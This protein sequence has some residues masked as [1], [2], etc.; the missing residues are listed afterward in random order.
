LWIIRSDFARKRMAA[1][2]FLA[3]LIH[4]RILV[5]MTE[6]EALNK[7]LNVLEKRLAQLV[8][9]QNDNR[10]RFQLIS[11][12]LEEATEKNSEQREII[13]KLGR[14]LNS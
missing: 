3:L 14:A 6:I 10:Q 8:D 5:S 13:R 11:K 7:R 9:E 4:R 2:K 12:A 1:I